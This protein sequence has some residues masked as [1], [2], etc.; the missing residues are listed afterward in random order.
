MCIRGNGRSSRDIYRNS[1]PIEIPGRVFI[2]DSTHSTHRLE[3]Q[4]LD[5]SRP[6]DP[7]M[8]LRF[9]LTHWVVVEGF[10]LRRS[11]GQPPSL[12]DPRGCTGREDFCRLLCICIQSNVKRKRFPSRLTRRSS[13]SLTSRSNTRKTRPKFP[14]LDRQQIEIDHDITCERQVPRPFS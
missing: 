10:R 1:I 12:V 2:R 3:G 9:P 4:G 13:L 11:A 6:I 5:F 7:V 8:S 14:Q